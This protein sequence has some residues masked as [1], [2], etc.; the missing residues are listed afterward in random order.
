MQTRLLVLLTLLAGITLCSL[1]ATGAT[2]KRMDIATLTHE[3]KDVVIGKV[4]KVES[5]WATDR[6]Q[7]MTQITVDV[8]ESFKGV[9]SGTIQISQ[10]GGVVGD[11]R[12]TAGGFP[13]FEEGKDVLLFLNDNPAGIIPTVG[14]GQGKYDILTDPQTGVKTVVNDLSGIEYL[15]NTSNVKAKSQR[16]TLNELTDQ[17]RTALRDGNNNK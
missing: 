17:I 12:A 6:H 8:S 7:I 9:S 11:V 10:I 16:L 5:N 3:A 13:T 2:V 15:N 1:S 14:L 4:T